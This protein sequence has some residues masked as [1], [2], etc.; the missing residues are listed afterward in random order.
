K[1]SDFQSSLSPNDDGRVYDTLHNDGNDHSFSSNVDECEDD[2]ATSMGETSIFEGNVD[3]NSDIVYVV[4][5]L[6]QYMHSPLNSYL[7]AALRV[8]GHLKGSPRGGIQINKIGNLKLRAYADSDLARSF[9]KAEYRSMASATC[10][11]IWLSNLLGDM[12]VKNLLPLLMYCDN[13]FAL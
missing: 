13:S 6:S 3:I 9:A 5:C 7:D 1:N 4:H 11:V 12:G 8:L 2:F 10:E